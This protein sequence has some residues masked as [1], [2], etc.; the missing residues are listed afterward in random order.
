MITMVDPN[1]VEEKVNTGSLIC[2]WGG[3]KAFF[4]CALFFVAVIKGLV[5]G[6]S[7]TLKCLMI[8]GTHSGGE[9]DN[10]K[11]CPQTPVFFSGI[12][13]SGELVE[14]DMIFGYFLLVV[15]LPFLPGHKQCRGISNKVISWFYVQP[16]SKLVRK[17]KVG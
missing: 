2:A 14:E 7:T 11:H 12:N 5:L 15:R 4:L 17:L 16:R 8:N 10:D 9:E 3:T 1:D 13:N 6:I